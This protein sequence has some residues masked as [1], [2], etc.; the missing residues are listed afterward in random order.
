M[1]FN[2]KVLSAVVLSPIHLS[3]IHVVE[4]TYHA[5][6][7]QTALDNGLWNLSIGILCRPITLFR[8]P[9]LLYYHAEWKLLSCNLRVFTVY[10]ELR[11]RDS[12][13]RQSR[14]SDRLRTRSFGEGRGSVLRDWRSRVKHNGLPA[15]ILSQSIFQSQMFAVLSLLQLLLP[16]L[17]T[18]ASIPGPP[19]ILLRGP[20]H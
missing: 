8:R 19:N 9:P 20:I 10:T 5:K 4:C 6:N 14:A 12:D 11:G 16:R 1:V 15:A 13:Q 7:N 2:F 18:G 17:S 3:D